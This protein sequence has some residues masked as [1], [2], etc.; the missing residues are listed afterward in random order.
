MA[1]NNL[2]NP[3]TDAYIIKY[4]DGDVSLER[5]FSSPEWSPQ[6]IVHTVLE[7]ETL[8]GIAFRYYGDSGK[9]GTIADANGIF[10]AFTDIEA[11][12]ELIIP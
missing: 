1:S 4:K 12:D 9:W 8:Q 5:N 6:S 2:V 7:G 11:G 3:Y 10:N